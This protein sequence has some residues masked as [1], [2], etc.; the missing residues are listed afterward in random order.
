MNMYAIF[1]KGKKETEIIN[2]YNST[3]KYLLALESKILIP[4]N[5]FELEILI[6][7]IKNKIKKLIT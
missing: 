4:L 3:L 7:T 1:R 6:A 2:D 5:K